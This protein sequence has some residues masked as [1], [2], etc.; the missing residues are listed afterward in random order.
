ME[1]L[2]RL[3]L[4]GGKIAWTSYQ[5]GVKSYVLVTSVLEWKAETLFSFSH[6]LEMG[7]DRMS[8][9]VRVNE[10]GEWKPSTIP[11][12][13]LGVRAT[14]LGITGAHHLIYDE[15]LNSMPHGGQAVGLRVRH[16]TS[17]FDLP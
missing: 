5:H 7:S 11:T 9:V 14:S 2:T 6:S 1:L 16:L 12:R 4:R 15:S 10:G 13:W 17:S 3:L 8:P